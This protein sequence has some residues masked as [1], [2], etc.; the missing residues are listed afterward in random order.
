MLGISRDSIADQK[1]FADKN[2][3][4]FSLLA[5][6]DGKVIHAYGVGNMVG[7][8]KRKTY[9]VDSKGRIAKYYADVNPLTHAARVAE[10]LA[11][12]S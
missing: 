10:D 6:V 8:A 9:L 7:L 4:K 12:I 3:L 1:T 2:K 11:K 5:D